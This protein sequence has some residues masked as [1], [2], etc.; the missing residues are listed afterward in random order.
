MNTSVLPR[1]PLRVADHR[2]HLRPRP[3]AGRGLRRARRCGRLR[4]PRTATR[5]ATVA[6]RIAGS[7][8]IVGDVARK[9]DVHPIAL[10]VGAALGG[11]DVLVNNASSLGPVPLAPAR[12]HRVRGPRGGARHQPVGPFRLTKALLGLL[13]G[14]ARDG[15]AAGTRSLVL[16]VSSDAAVTPYAGWGAYGASKAALAHLSRIW[17]EELR[18]HGVARRR[19]RPG[20]HGHAAARPRRARRRSGDA[21]AAA[22]RGARARRPHRARARRWRSRGARHE[23]RRRCRSSGRATRACW[24]SMPTV[25][26]RHAR[27][28]DLPALLAA[29]DLVVANDAA[30]LPASLA[31]PAPAR[32]ARRSRCAW[33]DA[34]SLGA[35]DEAQRFSAVVFG[36]GDFRTRTEDRPPPPPLAPGDGWRSGRSRRGAAH[37][38]PSAPGRAPLRRRRR[39]GERRHR[40]PRPAGA[41][42]A[43]RR[44]ARALG[45]V[46]ADRRAAGRLRAAVGRLRPR[47]AA[48]RRVPPAR[49]RL[50][51]PDPCR[52]PVVDRRS[53]ARRAPAVRRALSPAGI[54]RRRDRRR[55]GARRPHRRHRHDRRPRPRA[56]RGPR[57]RPARRRRHRHQP[58]RPRAAAC[59]SSTCSSAART[60]RARATTSCCAPSSANATLA[61]IDAALEGGGCRT[62]EFGDSVWIERARAQPRWNLNTATLARRFGQVRTTLP[63]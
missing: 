42:R 36:A 33:P 11:L 57:R 46:D 10:Q 5:V 18:P 15:V 49:H 6:R 35:P 55:E 14:A 51:D 43:P 38:R 26:S 44:A 41:V 12:R 45:R 24:S 37:A 32:A 34:P 25:A 3:G 13:A 30:T 7:H 56:R 8:G 4:R 28:R 47:L 48:A 19:R 63:A 16:N 1:T 60:S 52:R 59:A 40:P 23:G 20:R 17:D 9:E 31:R 27:A 29:G 22:R 58:A 50:R 39:R 53:G 21:E 62:H 54:D 2:R 61:R